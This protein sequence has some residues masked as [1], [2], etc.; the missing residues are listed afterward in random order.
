MSQIMPFYD[1]FYTPTN[2]LTNTEKTILILVVH[3]ALHTSKIEGL[4]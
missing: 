4:K 2:S 1:E 3:I